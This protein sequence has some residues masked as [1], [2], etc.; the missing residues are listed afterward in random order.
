MRLALGATAPDVLR[1]VVLQGMRLPVAGIGIGMVAALG[2]TRVMTGLLF[3]TSPADPLTYAAVAL[4]L[5]A[6][7]LCACLVPAL[8]AAR[9]NPVVVLRS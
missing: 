4:T 8:R 2:L 5:G 6:V 1:M 9:L 7:A 3:G